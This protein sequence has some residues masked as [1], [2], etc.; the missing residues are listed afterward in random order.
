LLK[1]VLT[2][3]TEFWP[4]N[5]QWPEHTLARPLAGLDESYRRGVLGRTASGDYG[6]P[7]LLQSLRR[8]NLHGVF[9]V[10]SLSSSAIGD[11]WLRRTVSQIVDEGQEVQLHLHTEWLSDVAMPGLPLKPRQNLS[12]F[13]LEEQTAIVRYGLAKLRDAGANNVIALRAGNMGGNLDTPSAAGAAGLSLD[14]SFDPSRGPEIRSL[15]YALRDKSRRENACPTVP[16]SFVQDYP[17]HYRPAQLTAL[18][19]RELRRAMRTAVREQWPCFVILLHSFELVRG[20]RQRSRPLRRHWINIARWDKL[21]SFLALHRDVFATI[22]C[23]E[24]K[25]AGESSY[26]PKTS[27]TLPLDTAWRMGEQFASRFI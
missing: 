15:L 7:Y 11:A 10:E 16:L 12:D 14:M 5:E 4:C 18:S 27:R 20:I 24:L 26:M 25:T 6:L 13:R 9:F 22:G 8:H 3:D 1:V 19:F 23:H 17:G 21:C 2:I